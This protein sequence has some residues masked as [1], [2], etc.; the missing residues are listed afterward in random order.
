MKSFQVEAR[1]L[2]P[3]EGLRVGMSVLVEL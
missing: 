2:Q 3:V 1:P